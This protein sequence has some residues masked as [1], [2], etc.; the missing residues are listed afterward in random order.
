MPHK[1]WCRLAGGVAAYRLRRGH[2]DMK[3]F[4]PLANLPRSLRRGCLLVATSLGIALTL[5]TSARSADSP[6]AAP[7]TLLASMPA[8]APVGA[9]AKADC[10]IID[11]QS[12]TLKYPTTWKEAT[13]DPD[14][15]PETHFTINGPDKKNSYVT[16]DIQDNAAD[17]VK[18]LSSTIKDLDGSSI[19]AQ[20]KTKL[21]A[22][23]SFKGTGMELK[24]RILD[25]YPGGIK[26][27]IFTSGK[28]SVQVIECYWTNELKDLQPDIDY[29]QQNFVV[30]N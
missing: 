19:S 1:V 25:T 9:A 3:I 14:Y 7:A 20:S 17:P 13:D 29:I 10:K 15:K 16:F 11:R 5:F 30:K 26:V 21:D 22:W 6:A 23:G 28:H 4:R 8:A 2:S 18:L 12:F 24:G 27:F